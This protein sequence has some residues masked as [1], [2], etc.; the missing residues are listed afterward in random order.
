MARSGYETYRNM[1][2][3]TLIAGLALI[4]GL[5]TAQGAYAQNA[6]DSANHPAAAAGRAADQTLGTNTT[7]TNPNGAM[8]GQGAAAG[9]SNQAVATTNENAAQPAHGANSFTKGEA[10]RRIASHGFQKV[11][12]LRKDN[13]GV[14]RGTATKDGTQ[15]QV[16]LDYKG[17][18]GQAGN[19]SQ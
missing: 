17:N 14:W 7:G 10:R 19:T 2:M 6:N 1:T 5:A 3:K 8:A 9:N 12:G 4:G 15:T 11:S 18:V 13:Q 16:W